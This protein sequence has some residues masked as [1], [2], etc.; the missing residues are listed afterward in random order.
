M[1]D[2]QPTLYISDLHL[3][4]S[5][6]QVTQ[7]FLNFLGGQARQSRALYILGDLFEMWLGDDYNTVH[8]QSVINGLHQLT[9]TGVSVYIMHGNRDFLLGEA[10]MRHTGAQLLQDP[11]KTQIDGTPVLLMHGDTLCT[12]DVD[13]QQFRAQVRESS[14]QTAFLSQ[15]IEERLRFAHHARQTSENQTRYK[16]EAI[17]DVNPQAVESTMSKH[18]VTLLIHGH[19]HRPDT[20]ELLVRGKPAR[21]IVLGDWYEQ[22]S[23][24]HHI[25]NQFVLHN[26]PLC[27]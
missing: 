3:D 12:D 8:H 19:T 11:F 6:P 5:R 25:N 21:R 27:C 24:L 18:Q 14:W 1:A 23:V 9:H 10:F 16:P 13:Y 17:M 7:L 20:H 22:G 4:E 26:L 2:K 15:S